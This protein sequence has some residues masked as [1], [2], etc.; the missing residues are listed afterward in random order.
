MSRLYLALRKKKKLRFLID[1]RM[2]KHASFE[3]LER[4]FPKRKPCLVISKILIR[5]EYHH[6]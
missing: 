2:Q 3:A 1:E 6:L 5:C 4:T